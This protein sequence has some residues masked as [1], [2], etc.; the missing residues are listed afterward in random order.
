M[1]FVHITD[2]H[3][4]STPDHTLHGRPTLSNLAVLVET[5]NNLPFRP[6]FILHNGDI[7][8]IDGSTGEIMRENGQVA[9]SLS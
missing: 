8:V 6:D 3:V 7:V 5:I 9:H 4:G 2:T 1:R